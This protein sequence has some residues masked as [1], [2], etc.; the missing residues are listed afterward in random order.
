MAR[1]PFSASFERAN[2]QTGARET[3]A[4]VGGGLAEGAAAVGQTLLDIGQDLQQKREKESVLYADNKLSQYRLD[5]TLRSQE[6]EASAEAGAPDFFNNRKRELDEGRTAIL[7]DPNLTDDARARLE[8]GLTNTD[9]VI[10]TGAANFERASRVE[11]QTLQFQQSVASKEKRLIADPSQYE[12]T[13][14]ELNATMATVAPDMDA[15]EREKLITNERHA[16]GKAAFNGAILRAT[17]PEAAQQLANAVISDDSVWRDRL[18]GDDYA[19]AVFKSEQNIITQEA[20]RQQRENEATSEAKIA[21]GFEFNMLM[22]D[23]LNGSKGAEDVA[24]FRDNANIEYPSTGPQLL[25]LDK[26]VTAMNK[27]RLVAVQSSVS[28]DLTR[29]V[30]DA[31][32]VND[33]ATIRAA[34]KQADFLYERN[35]IGEKQYTALV[36]KTNAG[37]TGAMEFK[38]QTDLVGFSITNGVPLDARNKDHT[39]AVDAYYG[40]VVAQAKYQELSPQVKREADLAM[41]KQTKIIPSQ[42][43]SNIRSGLSSDNPDVVIEAARMV[44]DIRGIGPSFEAHPDFSE[45]SGII[46]LS[47][48]ILQLN[49]ALNDPALAV[50]RINEAKKRPSEQRDALT[51]QFR[52]ETSGEDATLAIDYLDDADVI[53]DGSDPTPSENMARS[54]DVVASNIYSTMAVPNVKDARDTAL[55]LL[56]RTWGATNIGSGF[57]MMK[58]PPEKFYAHYGD[59]TKDAEWMNE[60]LKS[61]LELRRGELRGDVIL[62]EDFTD[63]VDILI[64]P[65]QSNN[66]KPVYSVL[67]FDV[68]GVPV[69][70]GTWFPDWATSKDKM[71]TDIDIQRKL[72]E[73]QERRQLQAPHMD[74][75]ADMTARINKMQIERGAMINPPQIEGP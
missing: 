74:A 37:L 48:E 23:V 45:D 52:S 58:S 42:V 26:A 64:D 21:Q 16:L 73:T 63:R 62:P 66:G 70:L 50:E 3:A 49:R 12:L 15:V 7:D 11:N 27:S 9:T 41:I 10:L 6:L 2:L 67:G 39:K 8:S 46:K 43:M 56:Q 51:S 60:Q 32:L 40:A 17:T 25:S 18:S 75:E 33:Y 57:R 13:L 59:A 44:D 22:M 29:L 34:R 19:A 36:T 54:L 53:I 14:M 4:S 28:G 47:S 69:N 31:A 61:D 30:D 20:R 1:I 68:N 24:L 38:D 5:Q 55:K 72:R 71:S 65:R 35:E